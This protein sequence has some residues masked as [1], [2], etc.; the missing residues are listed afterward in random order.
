[1]LLIRRPPTLT[2]TY[3][4]FPYTTLSRPP[5][6]RRDFP[7][8][9]PAPAEN[10]AHLCAAPCG[11]C[12]PAPPLRRGPGDQDQRQRQRQQPLHRRFTIA[13][14]SRRERRPS[15]SPHHNDGNHE[16]PGLQDRQRAGTDPAL[17]VVTLVD[18]L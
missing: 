15:F 5:R 6:G 7:R 12:P 3:T 16:S 14:S 11:S 1:M 2:R 13:P 18:P 10:A 17:P 9:H 4:L 8:G